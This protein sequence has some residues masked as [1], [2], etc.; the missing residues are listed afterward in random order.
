MKYKAN[1]PFKVKVTQEKKISIKQVGKKNSK[2]SVLIFSLI[3]KFFS[4]IKVLVI[5]T[6]FIILILYF[7]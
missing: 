4:D 3:N 2:T 1:K 7:F 6:N 5:N